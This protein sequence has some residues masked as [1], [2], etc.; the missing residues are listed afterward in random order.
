MGDVIRYFIEGMSK[1]A[2]E[3]TYVAMVNILKYVPGVQGVDEKVSIK[4]RYLTFIPDHLK[5]NGICDEAVPRDPRLQYNVP[6]HFKT[7]DM[8]KWVVEENPRVLKYVT[9]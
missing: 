8:C 6:D 9:D 4:L 3:L 2:M 5:T 1:E 7:Q